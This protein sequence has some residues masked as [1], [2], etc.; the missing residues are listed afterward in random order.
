MGTA[1]ENKLRMKAYKIAGHAYGLFANGQ[2]TGSLGLSQ[3]DFR[4]LGKDKESIVEGLANK[5]YDK[6]SKAY[7]EDKWNNQESIA[8]DKMKIEDLANTLIDEKNPANI[9]KKIDFSSYKDLIAPEEKGAKNWYQMDKEQIGKAMTDRGFNPKNR[10]DVKQ[11][12][13]KLSEHDINYNRGKIVDETLQGKS[14]AS[15]LPDEILGVKVPNSPAFVQKLA[16]AAYPAMTKEATRQSLTG[17]FDDGKMNRAIVADALAGGAMAAAPSF[18][19]LSGPLG[20]GL[21]AAGAETARQLIQPTEGSFSDVILAGTTAGT[22]PAGG[23]YLQGLLSRGA[24]TGARQYSRAFARGLRGADDP[25]MQER[26]A[27]KQLLI[28]ARK[29]SEKAENVAS[30]TNGNPVG[31]TATIPEL[32]EA[33]KWSE[34]EAK[35]N[36]LGYN[37]FEQENMLGL[38]VKDAEANLKAAT[39]AE[40]KAIAAKPKGR[41]KA[42]II[43]HEKDVELKDQI[44]QE[45]QNKYDEAVSKQKAFEDNQVFNERMVNEA[46]QNV[47]DIIGMDPSRFRGGPVVNSYEV[48][49]NGVENALK[50]YDQA[51]VFYG[52]N[53]E[54]PQVTATSVNA[55]R[56]MLDKYKSAFPQMY[57]YVSLAD[58]KGAKKNA[59]KAALLAGRVVGGV[60]GRMEPNTGSTATLITGGDIGQ[61]VTKFRESDWYKKLPKEKKNAIENALK[62]E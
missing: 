24:S 45:A 17:D 10:N 31:V 30:T 22:V 48:T 50:I 3:G 15:L 14:T 4:K 42:D 9:K 20:A 58:G 26:N 11:F 59:L 16:F 44:R 56:P 8:L 46:D 55:Y 53:E 7:P 60:G 19:V 39:E 18:K 51:P 13:E 29:Q 33:A 5:Y 40:R 1:R 34:A 57:E 62:G 49:N 37:S 12:F 6:L 23:Q 52:I 2:G 32:N 21:S 43:D 28:D 38:A 61:K 41:K 25:L 54:I 36:A 47:E 35:L 27:L